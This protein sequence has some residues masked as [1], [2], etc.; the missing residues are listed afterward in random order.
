MSRSA[1]VVQMNKAAINEGLNA[2]FET[3]QPYEAEVFGFCFAACN[4]SV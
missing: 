3:G 2:D 1:V 4:Q